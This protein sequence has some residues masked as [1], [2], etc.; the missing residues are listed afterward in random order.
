MATTVNRYTQTQE[1]R[2]Q[3]RTLQELMLAPAYKRGKHDEMDASISEYETALAQFSG[4]DTHDTR[5]KEEQKKLY[6]K[7]T[8]QRDKL[9][10]EGFS[11]SSK[12][13]FIRFNKEYQKAIGPQGNIGQI[14]SAKDSFAKSR[15]QILDVAMKQLNPK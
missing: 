7:M 14:Q 2:Y 9:N 8:S 3:P 5:L 4:M 1:N 11:Q 15:Q 12:S 13:D 6:D 10:E